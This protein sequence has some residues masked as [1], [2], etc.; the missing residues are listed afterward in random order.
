MYTSWKILVIYINEDFSK[1]TLN[2]R[3]ELWDDVKQLRG[4]GY[5]AVI[6]FDGI[7]TTNGMKWC[8]NKCVQLKI[9]DKT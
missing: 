3:V 2:I 4:E 1:A 6:K 9:Y 5:H 8:G 7:V